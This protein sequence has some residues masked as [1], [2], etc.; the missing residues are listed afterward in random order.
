MHFVHDQTAS[1]T[2][3]R[4]LT[5]MDVFSRGGGRFAMQGRPRPKGG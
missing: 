3:F 1:G 5:V 4:V 2:T